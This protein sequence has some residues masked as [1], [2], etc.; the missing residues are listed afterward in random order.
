HSAPGCARYQP[1]CNP[2]GLLAR[3]GA[4]NV[5]IGNVQVVARD[6]NVKIVLLGD[7]DSVIQTKHELPVLEQLVDARAVREIGLWDMPWG[8]RSERVREVRAALR[9]ILQLLC[10][11]RGDEWHTNQQ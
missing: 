7:G 1:R 6:G 8:V 11:R 10:W 2:A 4:Q 9:V 5:S 3:L